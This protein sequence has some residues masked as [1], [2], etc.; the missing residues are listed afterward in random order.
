MSFAV[1]V[2][3]WLAL[4]APAAAAAAAWLW[5]RRMRAGAAWAARGLWDRLLA[6]YSR[7]RL[8]ASVALLALAVLGTALALARPRWGES[9]ERVERRGVDVVFV[10]DSSLSMAAADAPP[11]RLGV[12][13]T[14]VRRLVA[15]LPGH[16]VALIQT[17]GE[18]VVAAPLTVDGAVIDLLLDTVEPGSLP[19]PGSLLAPALRQALRLFPPGGDKHRVVVL[20][21]DGEDHGGGV[22]EVVAELAEERV[23]VH[24]LGVGTPQGAPLPLPGGAPNQ[25]KRDEHGR[26]VISRLNEEALETA[27]RRTGGLYLRATSAALDLQPLVRRID[28]ME[29]RV[30]DTEEVATQEERFQWALAAA[31]AGLLLWLALPPFRPEP[32]AEGA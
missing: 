2:L 1:P 29:R 20:V 8:A 17:E 23:V 10:L 27:T 18:S 9:A 32:G 25:V 31:T 4:L 5:R 14:L 24:A 16:R 30:L 7:G 11:S 6:G 26:V 12:A 28:A 19:V 21:S 3:L 13:R 22:E 15:A